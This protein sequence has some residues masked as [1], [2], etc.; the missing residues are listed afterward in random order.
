MIIANEKVPYNQR[1]LL[2]NIVSGR[3]KYT[4]R[5]NKIYCDKYSFEGFLNNTIE[6]SRS[7]A[8]FRL[9]IEKNIIEKVGSYLIITPHQID[10]DTVTTIQSLNAKGTIQNVSIYTDEDKVNVMDKKTGKISQF[11]T[12]QFTENYIIIL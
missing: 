11:S 10:L 9:L 3:C 2:I 4:E 1:Q 12:N 6:N 8:A 7:T 5:C